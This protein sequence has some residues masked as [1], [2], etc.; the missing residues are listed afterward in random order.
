MRGS[1][2]ATRLSVG[3]G[4]DFLEIP[5]HHIPFRLPCVRSRYKL[6]SRYPPDPRARANRFPRLLRGQGLLRDKLRVRELWISSSLF[7]L[8]LAFRRGDALWLPTRD[9]SARLGNRDL[10]K[11]LEHGGRPIRGLVAVVS[12]VGR[13]VRWERPGPTFAADGGLCPELRAGLQR[14]VSRCSREIFRR[15]SGRRLR[16]DDQFAKRRGRIHDESRNRAR[17]RRR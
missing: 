8:L 16:V 2:E 14:L 15:T 17:G 12:H 5:E 3:D 1:A 9:D 11:W 7:L 6:R 4:S 13:S 10:A